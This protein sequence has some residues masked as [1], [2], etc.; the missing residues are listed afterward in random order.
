M[1]GIYG[2]SVSSG[3]KDDVLSALRRWNRFYGETEKIEETASSGDSDNTLLGG[4]HFAFSEKNALRSTVVCSG[5]YMAAIDAVLYNRSELSEILGGESGS[6]SDEELLLEWILQKGWQSLALVNG[7]FAGAVF[8]RKNKSWSLFSSHLGTRPLFY[9]CGVHSLIFSTDIRGISF[10]PEAGGKINEEFLYQKLAGYNS[11]L[12]ERTEYEKINAVPPAAWIEFRQDAEGTWQ[13]DKQIYWQPGQS[14]LRLRDDEAYARELRRL[15]EDAVR[16]RLKAADGP[17]GAEISGG[18]DSSIVAILVNRLGGKGVYHTW[19]CAPEQHPLQ[20]NDERVAILD[21]CRQENIECHFSDLHKTDDSPDT[22]ELLSRKHPFFVNTMYV[23]KG[24]A[25]MKSQG[26]RCVFTGY[27]GDEGISHKGNTAELWYH[28]EYKNLLHQIWLSAENIRLRRLCTIKRSFDFLIKTAPKLKNPPL[29]E[30]SHMRDYIN[31]DFCRKMDDTVPKRAFF[32]T[33]DPAAYIMQGGLNERIKNLALQGA[34]AGVQYVYPYL[35][36]RVID[37]A[38]SIP[39]NQYIRG[40]ITRYVYRR[41]FADIMPKSFAERKNAKSMGS[42]RNM[43][44]LYSDERGWVMKSKA[45]QLERMDKKFWEQYLDIS[46]LEQFSLPEDC[47]IEQL[48]KAENMIAAWYELLTI[49]NCS[50][51]EQE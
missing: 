6:M 45:E 22:M 49:A 39:R 27:G 25:W 13:P 3:R 41:A 21:I 42:R 5:D 34:E 43:P 44:P 4:F 14:K 15:A 36:Y 19:A 47:T 37:F 31:D 1:S 17:V 35:D 32:I 38:L 48:R 12:N 8:S 50:Y 46:K 18:L 16:C 11:L 40:N 30:Y 20:N 29:R 10:L 23:G 24:A 2:F 9:F 26:A 51:K 33:Y 28:K 7:D